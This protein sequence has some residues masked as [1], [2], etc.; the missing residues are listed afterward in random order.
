MAKAS[1]RDFTISS[2]GT[3]I[4]AVRTKAVRWNGTPID[5]TSDDDAG[6]TTFLAAEFASTTL[7]LSVEGIVD[8]D[9]LADAAFSAAHADKHLSNI[10]LERANGDGISGDFILTSYEE[11]GEY[12]GSPTFSATL[13]RNGTHTLTPA[14]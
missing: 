13:V 6:D 2:G 5:V 10:T 3:V 11:T 7:E 9:V 4:A 1:S 12:Q 8:G 14:A